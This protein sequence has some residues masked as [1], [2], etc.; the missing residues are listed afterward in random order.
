MQLLLIHATR[1]CGQWSCDYPTHL[2]NRHENL[3][4]WEP[5][6]VPGHCKVW[7]QS[8]TTIDLA[9]LYGEKRR[10]K[11]RG[12]KEKLEVL[13][14]HNDSCLSIWVTTSL[15]KYVKKL[16]RVLHMEERLERSR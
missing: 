16:A 6:N 11:R 10:R 7:V 12:G 1:G 3:L 4:K 8:S 13:D 14:L 15:M 2:G 9:C 5:E